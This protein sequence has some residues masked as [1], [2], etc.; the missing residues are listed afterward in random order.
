MDPVLLQTRQKTGWQRQNLLLPVVVNQL[1]AAL[2]GLLFQIDGG[3]EA[4]LQGLPLQSA[5]AETVNG[6]DVGAIEA[7]QGQQQPP[8]Q[9][10]GLA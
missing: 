9:P 3:S 2:M 4:R 10:T 6:G 7:F 8:L 5:P 1:F